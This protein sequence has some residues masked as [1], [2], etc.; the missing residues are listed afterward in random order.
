MKKISVIIPVYNVEKYL[1]KCLDSLINQNFSDY[2]IILVNDGS[3]D[4]SQQIIDKYKEKHPNIIFNYLQKNKGQGAARNLGVSKARGKYICFVDSDDYVEP[5]FMEELYKFATSSQY[6]IIVF[7]MYK[8]FEN[9]KP[10]EYLKGIVKYSDSIQKNYI[11]S[12]AGPCNKLIKRKVWVDNK[13]VFL[14]N[15]IYEDL[16]LIPTIAKYTKNIGYFEKPLYNYLIHSGSTMN[17]V[18]YSKKLKDIFKVVDKLYIELE[19]DFYEEL[20]Y[21]YI[22]NLLHGAGLRFLK[23]KEGI[24]D[25]E[26]IKSIMNDKFPKWRKNKYLKKQNFRYKVICYL[27]Y[28]KRIRTLN[29]ILNKQ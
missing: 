27:I 16:A 11:L 26:H 14:E 2:E 5:N 25:I 29:I 20:E 19:K 8:R 10:K 15:T 6:D 24:S 1:S 12:L 23:F 7:D 4:N 9:D 18:T 17:Q 22:T 28:K 13:L 3:T 21:L